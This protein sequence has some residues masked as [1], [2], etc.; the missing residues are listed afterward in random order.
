VTI[1]HLQDLT[2]HSGTTSKKANK[3]LSCCC[4]SRSYCIWHMV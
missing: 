3:K 1:N 4:E 2:V